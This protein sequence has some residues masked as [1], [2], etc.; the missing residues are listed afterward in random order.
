[1]YLLTTYQKTTACACILLLSTL[2]FVS[3]ESREKTLAS[4]EA[5]LPT[6]LHVVYKELTSPTAIVPVS[7]TLVKPI[8]YKN[9]VSFKSLPVAEKKQKFIDL[10]LP[11]ILV[12]K[13]DLAQDRARVLRI[14]TD[15]S[16]GLTPK[17]ED[18]L[19]IDSLFHVFRTQDYNSLLVKL[20]THPVSIVLGQAIIEC[21][22]GTSRF[23][24]AG[25][26]VFGI[27][28]FDPDDNRIK[29]L[30][31][32]QG[33]KNI[34][35]RKYDD[36]TS[37]VHDYFRI[38]GKM[39]AYKTFRQKRMISD[40]PFELVSYLDNYSELGHDYTQK[41]KQIIRH[42]NLTQ[43]DDYRIDPSYFMMPYQDENLFAFN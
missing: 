39:D 19:F 27:W 31:Q 36:I 32:R 13:Y 40:D 24:Q 11:A 28:S 35:V 12:A 20:Q 41:L 4:N 16:M 21:G 9:A 23:F 6:T 38:L 33:G 10:M 29:A 15:V 30:G 17:P 43:Y 14:K 3:C 34:Y 1:M 37:S 22:W 8:V 5:L 2:F 25:A 42:N 18:K 7:D 26:N